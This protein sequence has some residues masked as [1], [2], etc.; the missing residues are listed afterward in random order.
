METRREDRWT[1]WAVGG[2]LKQFLRQK[3]SRL[4][5]SLLTQI[6]SRKARRQ[7]LSVIHDQRAQSMQFPNPSPPSHPVISEEKSCRRIKFPCKTTKRREET[8]REEK[9]QRGRENRKRKKEKKRKIFQYKRN[10]YSARDTVMVKEW[11]KWSLLNFNTLFDHLQHSSSFD[12]S[13]PSSLSLSLAFPLLPLCP[14]PGFL[15][16]RALSRHI[17][18]CSFSSR[19]FS[20]LCRRADALAISR[21]SG[22]AR[23]RR[24][25]ETR[26]ASAG[27]AMTQSQRGPMDL[28]GV[29]EVFGGPRLGVAR[30]EGCV[31]RGAHHLRHSLRGGM[32]KCAP[33]CNIIPLGG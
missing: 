3:P 20:S 13:L 33:G 32:P 1:A 5:V 7:L 31:T 22:V 29:R 24:I 25:R 18:F 14:R 30:A 8:R 19:S 11:S 26:G 17:Q 2:A 6:P 9:T 28:A 23:W 16:T 15:D 12:F 4:E 10:N 27:V 21:Q